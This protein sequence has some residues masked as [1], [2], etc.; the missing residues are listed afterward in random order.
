MRK[1]D[2]GAL[3]QDGIIK[4]DVYA[5]NATYDI[6]HVRDM[7]SYGKPRNEW[8]SDSSGSTH[9][10]VTYAAELKIPDTN[11]FHV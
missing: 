3:S 1:L 6:E 2:A 7:E 5:N 4:F 8:V 10:G 11:G 9:E